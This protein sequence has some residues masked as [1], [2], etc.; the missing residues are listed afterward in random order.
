MKEAD[1]YN[2]SIW[3]AYTSNCILLPV[4]TNVVIISL[5]NFNNDLKKMARFAK[6]DRF[7]MWVYSPQKQLV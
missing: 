5:S 4:V 7:S 3:Q 6:E 1:F 2:W